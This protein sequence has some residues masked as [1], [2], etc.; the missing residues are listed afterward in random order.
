[1]IDFDPSKRP[2]LAEIRNCKLCKTS[3]HMQAI[4]NLNNQEKVWIRR[5]SDSIKSAPSNLPAIPPNKSM[6]E[7]NLPNKLLKANTMNLL[8]TSTTSSPFHELQTNSCELNFLEVNFLVDDNVPITEALFESPT[9][10]SITNWAISQHQ[11]CKHQYNYFK[12]FIVFLLLFFIL[13]LVRL[14]HLKRICRQ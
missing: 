3:S 7:I 4:R 14:H 8:T 13:L 12:N 11:K 1:M 9:S 5:Q 10:R 6:E 2:N